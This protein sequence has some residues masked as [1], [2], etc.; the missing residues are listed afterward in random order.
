MQEGRLETRW[1]LGL[2]CSACP[3]TEVSS[4]KKILINSKGLKITVLVQ[5][6]QIMDKA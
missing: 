6:G 1:D 4:S 3:W 5:L 2:C